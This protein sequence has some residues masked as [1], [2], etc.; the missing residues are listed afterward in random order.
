M[1]RHTG[2]FA[3]ELNAQHDSIHAELAGAWDAAIALLG[4]PD[5]VERYARCT[6]V[7]KSLV[8]AA[9]YIGEEEVLFTE[10]PRDGVSSQLLEQ[11]RAEH[12]TLR[13]NISTLLPL[14]DD[15][16][17]VEVA[18]WRLLRLVASFESHLAQEALV[19]DE[20]KG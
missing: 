11:F 6:V 1:T 3:A 7:A 15:R 16:R 20:A 19:L 5:L 18:A 17:T 13:A 2:R 4:E 14:L 9:R 12:A 8:A 10:A